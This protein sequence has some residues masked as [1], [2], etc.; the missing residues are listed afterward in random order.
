MKALITGGSGFLASHLVPHLA[1]SGYQDLRAVDRCRPWYTDRLPCAFFQGDLAAIH[2]WSLLL[3]GI[4]TVFHLAWASIPATSVLNPVSDINDSLVPTVKLL[5]QCV[6]YGVKKVV[7]ISTGG[8]IYGLPRRY[9]IPEDHPTEPISAY[10][11]TKLAAEKYLALFHRLHGLEYTILRPSVAY[12][13]YQ[14]LFGQ[15]GAVAVFLGNILRGKPIDIWGDGNCIVRDF[16]YA[17][18]LAR[19]CVLSARPG[20][21]TGIYNLGGGV[22]IS[23]LDLVNAI[24]EVVG[25]TH[26]IEVRKLPNRTFDVP[27]VLL[28]ITKARDVLGWKPEVDLIAGI[29]RTWDWARTLKVTETGL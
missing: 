7:F 4:D 15:Q 10:G 28:D 12:G 22:G 6:K 25:K 1:N 27:S 19:A 11:I 9:P 16:I 13:E 24:S 3:D 26:A 17:R 5:E 21:P 29:R 14:N 8:A 18:D 2:D 23:L 20:G